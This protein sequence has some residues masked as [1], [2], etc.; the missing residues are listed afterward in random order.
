MSDPREPLEQAREAYTGFID[1]FQSL[2]L[3]TAD[4]QGSL[5]ASYAPYVRDPQGGFCIFVSELAEHTGNLLARGEASVLFIESE[6]DTRQVFARRRASFRC[7]VAELPR[8]TE[9]ADAILARFAGRFGEIMGL[10]SG[11]G[12][13]R[14][15]RLTPVEGRFVIGFGQAYRLVGPGLNDLVPIGPGERG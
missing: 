3:A 8:G 14:L 4:G 13:F 10:L 15:L 6:A 2:I 7:Q 9:E 1:G 11:L 5:L 12:D